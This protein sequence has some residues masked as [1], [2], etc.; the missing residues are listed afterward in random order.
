MLC[1][2]MA[3]IVSDYAI[4]GEESYVTGRRRTQILLIA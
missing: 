4:R 2:A 1:P 3:G